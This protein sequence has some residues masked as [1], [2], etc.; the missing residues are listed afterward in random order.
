MHISLFAFRFLF[1][2]VYTQILII[3]KG[4]NILWRFTHL[5]P[6]PPFPSG[7]CKMG[8]IPMHTLRSLSQLKLND[9]KLAVKHAGFI[10]IFN[11]CWHTY[12]WTHSKF[13]TALIASSSRTATG[14]PDILAENLNIHLIC[15][16]SLSYITWQIWSQFPFRIG[17][18]TRHLF[19]LVYKYQ[20]YIKLLTGKSSR[21]FC[22]YICKVA[23]W[24]ACKQ[25]W[26][27]G[28]RGR[29]L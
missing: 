7:A 8:L 5:D 25:W 22:H 13:F 14:T 23:L 2:N 28:Q 15:E 18:K 16:H 17:I 1:K 6:Q 4:W 3:I 21:Q 27:L 26:R 11:T 29:L 24:G 9:I 20:L 10:H 12:Q 19:P